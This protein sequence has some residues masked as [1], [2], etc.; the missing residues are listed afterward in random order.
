MPRRKQ[1]N[2]ICHDI[3]DSFVSRYN[4][5]DGYWALG[6]FKRFLIDNGQI[7]LRF[8]LHNGVTCPQNAR[9]RLTAAYYWEAILRMMGS[10]N[11]P[12]HW[13]IEASITFA[14]IDKSQAR[15]DI[16]IKSDL[17]RTYNRYRIVTIN[18]HDP[19]RESQ[20]VGNYGPSNQKR[21]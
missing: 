20:R 1:F 11:M 16:E 8:D 6:Q 14:I 19:C 10:F 13:L 21:R 12:G 18:A 4:D 3:L 9:F 5:L 17:N 2:G 7:Q 15:C